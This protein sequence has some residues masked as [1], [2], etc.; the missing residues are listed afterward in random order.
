MQVR[1]ISELNSRRRRAGMMML[2]NMVF[3]MLLALMFAFLLN[4]G[5]SLKCKTEGQHIADAAAYSVGL[6]KTRAMN[7]ITATNHAMGEMMAMV[8]VHH[9]LGG[10][11]LDQGLKAEAHARQRDKLNDLN[12]RL[13]LAYRLA[14]AAGAQ[15]PAYKTVRQKKG[16]RAEATILL[17]KM[18]LKKYLIAIY[19]AKVA[20]KAMQAYPPTRPAGEALEKA[21]DV[22]ELEI[23]AEYR[24]LNQYARIATSLL[25]V[26]SRI[27]DV[28]LPEAKRFTA[29]VVAQTP[30]IVRQTATELAGRYGA[31]EAFVVDSTLPVQL[32]PLARAQTLPK[33]PGADRPEQQCCEC[34]SVRTAIT[35]DQIVKTT[36]LARASFPW[37]VYHRQPIWDSLAR[38]A[39]LSMAGDYYKEFSDGY[40]KKL[41]DRYQTDHDHDLGLFVVKG[42]AAP[43]KGWEA[44]TEKREDA[45][46]AFGTLVVVHTKTDPVI[47][48]VV[49]EEQHALGQVFYAQSMIYNAN[50]QVPHPARIDLR[51]K[52]ITPNRQA[53]VGFDTLNW[54]PSRKANTMPWELIA[55]TDQ[56]PP[57]DPAFP[58]IR[59]NWQARLSPASAEQLEMLKTSNDLPSRMRPLINRLLD[60]VPGTLLSH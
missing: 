30:V 27:R 13:D 39:P 25:E 34:L 16:I 52:R 42:S 33:L 7:V 46:A 47:G 3:V 8:I 44:W 5:K 20:A 54:A 15:T 4:S 26:K 17:A 19:H 6:Q 31:A 59:V 49:F 32:D 29:E 50:P 12:A 9:A 2:V 48:K 23:L 38:L 18:K 58:R 36:Q 11:L 35:R 53:A 14:T 43:D 45:D 22:F 60:H 57:P 21:M 51:C 24:V 41:C 28:A 37:V 55:K 1:L 40:S 56:G 10:D